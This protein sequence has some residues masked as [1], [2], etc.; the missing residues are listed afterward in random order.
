MCDQHCV[1]GG[2]QRLCIELSK[3]NG[4]RGNM[5]LVFLVHV[6]DTKERAHK[7]VEAWRKEEVLQSTIPHDR[8]NS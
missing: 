7:S 8:N 3:H 2:F 1:L 5:C 6:P 4:V